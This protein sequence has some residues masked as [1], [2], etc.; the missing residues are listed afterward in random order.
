MLACSDISFLNFPHLGFCR[1]GGGVSSADAL[2]GK[3]LLGTCDSP[4]FRR[5]NHGAG[6]E[7]TPWGP[8]TKRDLHDHLVAARLRL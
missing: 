1:E 3:I 6:G 2:R 7:S 8:L 4:S 5:D